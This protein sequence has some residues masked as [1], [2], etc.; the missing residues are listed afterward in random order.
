MKVEPPSRTILSSSVVRNLFKAT[1]VSAP[2]YSNGKFVYTITDSPNGDGVVIIDENDG[3]TAEFILCNYPL[4]IESVFP[5]KYPSDKIKSLNIVVSDDN[6]PFGKYAFFSETTTLFGEPIL[7]YA[8][9]NMINGEIT[10]YTD[11]NL[12]EFAK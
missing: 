3:K 2:V 12:P 6:I 8:L 10:E 7:K 4:E 9:Q 5:Q 1:W 11:E